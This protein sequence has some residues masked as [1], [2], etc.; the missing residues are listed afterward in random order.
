MRARKRLSSR[1][2]EPGAACVLPFRPRDSPFSHQQAKQTPRQIVFRAASII[3]LKP[4]SLY[5]F[6]IGYAVRVGLCELEH[7]F[8]QHLKSKLGFLSRSKRKDD[9]FRRFAASAGRLHRIR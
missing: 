2:K 8:F 6:R 1:Y 9:V 3:A 5:H 7:G 4:E